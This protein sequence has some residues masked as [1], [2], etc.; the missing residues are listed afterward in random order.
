MAPNPDE[1]SARIT[2]V[3]EGDEAAAREMVVRLYPLVQ[4]IA[5]AHRPWRMAAEDLCQE[6]FLRVF[7][8]LDQYRGKVPFEHWVSRL[9][10]HTCIDHLR[11]Q[12]AR[13]ELRWADLDAAD[14]ATFEAFALRSEPDDGHDPG[15]AREL[16]G[17]LLETL[18]PKD[19]LLIQWLEIEDLSVREVSSRTGW[20]PTLVKVRAFRAR[21]RLRRA[22]ERLAREYPDEA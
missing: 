13:P 2:E 12:R 9:A 16:L 5:N 14:Q 3:R 20:N 7:A 11:R 22:W 6:V 15:L 21:G 17:R 8:C 19:R 1:W 4:R 18:D 10:V